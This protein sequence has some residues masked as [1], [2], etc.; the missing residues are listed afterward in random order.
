MRRLL[1]VHSC[2]PSLQLRQRRLAQQC[3]LGKR[4]TVRRQMELLGIV[5]IVRVMQ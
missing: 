3:Q 1:P 2:R 4:R 5:E